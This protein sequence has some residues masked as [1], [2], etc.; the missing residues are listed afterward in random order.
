MPDCGCEFEIKNKTQAHVLKQ[1]LLINALMFFIEISFGVIAESTALIADSLDMFADAAVYGVALYAVARSLLAKERAAKISGLLQIGLGLLV[2]ADVVRRFITGSEP[3]SVL[4]ILVGFVALVSNI[5]CLKL[6]S[7]HRD[8]EVHMRASWVFSK[9]DVIA[10]IG[11]ILSGVFV[12][13]SG[14]AI[15]DL[16]IGFI[17]SLIVVRGGIEI[18]R[19]VES[20]VKRC[21]SEE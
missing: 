16:V 12:Y 14:L 2:L 3:D 10:N 17:I 6:L 9:N 21:D 4:M 20:E 5:I 7:S 1:L 11:I 13:Y 18:L 19:D 8:G 15:A